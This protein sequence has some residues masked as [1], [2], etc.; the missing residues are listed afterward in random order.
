MIPFNKL[1]SCGSDANCIWL[2]VSL[3]LAVIPLETFII[4]SLRAQAV[5]REVVAPCYLHHTT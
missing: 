3:Y 5:L 2:I 1:I 4:C